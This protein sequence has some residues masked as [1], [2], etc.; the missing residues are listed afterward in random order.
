MVWI[1]YDLKAILYEKHRD[2]CRGWDALEDT[3]PSTTYKKWLGKI[4]DEVKALGA[5]PII[6]R[7]Y[8]VAI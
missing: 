2:D 3:V 7:P 1:G 4:V 8:A 5:T 6:V